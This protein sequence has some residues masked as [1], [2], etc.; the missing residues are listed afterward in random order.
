MT[1]L[2]IQYDCSCRFTDDYLRKVYQIPKDWPLPPNCPTHGAPASA[3][4]ALD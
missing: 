4:L 2:T 1:D 3:A